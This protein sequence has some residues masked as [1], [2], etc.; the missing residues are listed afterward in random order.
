MRL[1]FTHNSPNLNN[2]TGL[3]IISWQT[4]CL[5]VPNEHLLKE[6]NLAG[7]SYSP[8]PLPSDPLMIIFNWFLEN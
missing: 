8:G 5:L 6:H 4:L 2:V 1:Q 7:Y 3:V